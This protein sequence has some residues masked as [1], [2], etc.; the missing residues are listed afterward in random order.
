MNIP[1]HKY[2]RHMACLMKS[3][4][5]IYSL[6]DCDHVNDYSLVHEHVHGC[7]YDCDWQRH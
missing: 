5:L 1:V 6:S 7:D 3:Y 4:Y 2:R